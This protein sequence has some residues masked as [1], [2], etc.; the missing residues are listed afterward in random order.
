MLI[1]AFLRSWV[2]EFLL[3]E[4]PPTVMRNKLAKYSEKRGLYD[5]PK[6]E[7]QKLCM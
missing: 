5:E 7:E 2:S 1:F 3:T 4:M 6:T